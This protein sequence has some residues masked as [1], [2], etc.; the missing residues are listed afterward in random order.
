LQIENGQTLGHYRILRPLGTGGMGEV[1]EAEDTKLGR[2]VALKVLPEETARDPARRERF[3]REARAVA[4]LRHPGIVTI[5]SVEQA[6]GVDFITMELLE[7]QT[8][9]RTLPHTGLP[10]DRFLGLAI[11]LAEAMAAAHQQGITHRDLK[12]ENIVIGRDGGLKVVDFGL[13][14]RDELFG[15]GDSASRAPTRA[16]TEEGRIVGTV[17]YMSPEQAEGKPVDPRSDVF[18][19]GIIFYEMCTGERPFRGDTTVSVLSSILKDTPPPVTQV[20]ATLPRDV[21]RI[22]NR[23]LMKDP[24]RRFQS[25]VGLATELAELKHESD[26]GTLPA[27]TGE[28]RRSVTGMPAAGTATSGMS[29]EAARAAGAS[30]PMRYASIA[31]VVLAV[32]VAG[33]LIVRGRRTSPSSPSVPPPPATSAGAS[34]VASIPHPGA[35]TA[36][37]DT[38]QRIVVLPFENLGEPGDAYFAEGVTEEIT[39]RLAS[40]GGLGVISRHSAAQYA[41]T[42]KSTKEIGAELNVEYVLAG[43]VRWQRGAG[44]A[45]RV[46]VTP[47]LVRVSDDTQLWGDRYDRDMKDIFKVQSEIADQVVGKMGLAM[48]QPGAPSAGEAVPTGNLEAYQLYLRGRAEV[49]SPEGPREA[50]QHGIGLLEQAVRLDPRFAQAW[51]A[52]SYGHSY[53]YQM[54]Y[55][56]S[57]DRLAKARECVD[58]ALEIQPD[59]R[60]GH[61][62]LGY[63]YYW[64]RRDYAQAATEFAAAAGGRE[65]DPEA[66]AAMAYMMRRQGKWDEA[67]VAMERAYALNPRDVTLIVNLAGTYQSLWRYSEALRYMD[68]A[69]DLAHGAPD[70][71]LSKMFIL[72]ETGD[73]RA[74]REALEGID[75]REFPDLPALVGFL[76]FMDGRFADALGQLHAYPKDAI[77]AQNIYRPKELQEGFIYLAMSDRGRATTACD[78][79]RQRLE[80]DVAANPRD[81]R[82]RSALAEAHACLG[83]RE[84][85]VREAK[86]AADLVPV[87]TDAVDGPFYLEGLAIVYATLGDADAAIDVLEK[88]KSL[89]GS[90]TGAQLLKDAVYAPIR[91]HPRFKELLKIAH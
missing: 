76:D 8:L 44:G 80:K 86:L 17:A 63:Y 91:N 73:T 55:D 2:K 18:T 68:I 79:A 46:R 51:A 21:A 78:A 59:L 13:A 85:A 6:G 42:N 77:D 19:L 87:T 50:L 58:R 71:K 34:G 36:P 4:A 54:R 84:D 24:A 31:A 7:G 11:P 64:G 57:E 67:L 89:P 14:K 20:N 32:A 81:P 48:R 53:D 90:G 52:L 28:M 61:M 72:V 47:Q 5:Y 15:S 29:G 43:T 25:A 38:R 10:F 9:R 33:Y 62:A 56:F 75:A 70:V 41:R 69:L 45:S 60:E 83:H 37:G 66:L 35:P 30:A 22:V 3:E 88:F 40:V 74:A 49:D 39:S 12:P 27:V 23:C 16:L 65:D 82:M 26:S 1:Y